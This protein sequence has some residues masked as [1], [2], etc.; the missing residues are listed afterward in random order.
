M[1]AE[2]RIRPPRARW[3]LRGRSC[4]RICLR[5]AALLAV[6]HLVPAR[7]SAATF[8][9]SD[10]AS[11]QAALN[12]AEANG[13]DD[14]IEV[15]AGSYAVATTLAYSSAESRSLR[16]TGAG[17]GTTVLDGGGS[18]QIL[19]LESWAAEGDLVAEGLTLQNG[20]SSSSAGGAL[21]LETAAGTQTLTDCEVLDSSTSGEDGIGGGAS[22]VSDTGA[23]TVAGCAFRRNTSEANVG[24]LYVA[25]TTATIALFESVFEDNA[26]DNLGGQEYFGDGGGAMLYTDA[27][28]LTTVSGCTFTGN[29][30]TGGDNPDGGGLMIY[31]LGTGALATVESSVFSGNQAG[32]GG[33]G[34]FVRINATGTVH[35]RDNR[36]EDNVTLAG[37]GGGAFLYVD[38]GSVEV[39]GN[40]ATTNVAAADG[41]GIW[42]RHGSGSTLLTGNTFAGNQAGF[43]GGG[44]TLA[45]DATTATLSHNVFRDNGCAGVGAG[46]S[47]AT[48]NGSLELTRSTFYG[49]QAGAEGGGCYLY[50]EEETAPVDLADLI[51]WHDTPEELAYSSAG[52]TVT[53]EL[54]Y[55]DVEG[56]TGQSWF[57]PGCLDT[58][59]LFLDP[60]AGDLNLAW[61]TF[62]DAGPGQSPCIDAGDPA[63][64]PDPDGTRVDMGGLYFDQLGLIFGDGFE[65]GTTDAWEGTVP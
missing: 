48:G 56:G 39:T 57:G 63:S 21:H 53:V 8:P 12:A 20:H 19:R 65:D 23:V 61:P 32:L 38:G 35:C 2:T 1:V 52:G 25:V 51:L 44:L 22:L 40:T 3:L 60:A 49:N 33:A 42:I 46:L 37:S 11:F 55:S 10:P 45:T 13:E 64:A 54:R 41:G 18:T 43:N 26:V 62:P 14:V 31:L 5:T 34:L 36:F 7:V 16:I 6:L 59:P 9:V 24:G 47:Y 28:G 27:G 30:A 17:I 29:T 58:D 50:F 4:C 15:A